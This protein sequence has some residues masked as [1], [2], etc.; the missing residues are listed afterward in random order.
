MK[1]FDYS[2]YGMIYAAFGVAW[3][4]FILIKNVQRAINNF[5]VDESI[6]CEETRERLEKARQKLIDLGMHEEHKLLSSFIISLSL[7]VSSAWQGL[8]WP[9]SVLGYIS[10]RMPK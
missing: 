10:K 4:L 3:F 7:I 5:A 2:E 9:V 1:T 8:I 6:T